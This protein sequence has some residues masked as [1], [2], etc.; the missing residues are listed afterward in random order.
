MEGYNNTE[1]LSVSGIIISRNAL[2]AHNP[3]NRNPNIRMQGITYRIEIPF[4]HLSRPVAAKVINIGL[5]VTIGAQSR[6]VRV[7][8][9]IHYDESA[10]TQFKAD[11]D[12][13]SKVSGV[14]CTICKA[15]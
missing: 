5:C 1:I 13:F 8:P 7:H 2:N 11:L 4:M 3:V 12:H 10:D 6:V 14:T 9:L 15:S